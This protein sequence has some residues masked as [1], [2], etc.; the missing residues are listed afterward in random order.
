MIKQNEQLGDSPIT[1]L[2]SRRTFLRGAG[3]TSAVVSGAA[4]FRSLQPPHQRYDDEPVSLC[5]GRAGRQLSRVRFHRAESFLAILDRGSFSRQGDILYHAGIVAQ[6]GLSAHLLDV[7]FPDEWCARHIGL[8]VSKSLAYA[9]ATGLGYPCADMARLAEV[10]TPYWK[11]RQPQLRDDPQPY[12]GGYTAD[13]V[14]MLLRALLDH[15][16]IV[17]GHPRPAGW[18]R[19]EPTASAS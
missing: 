11:W 16:R 15:I 4:A 12:D 14:H 7:G 17:T 5:R 6:L 1:S 18:H 9:N 13:A 10:L 3:I 2:T 19:R 8:R